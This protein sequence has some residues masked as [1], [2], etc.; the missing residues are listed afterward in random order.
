MT[1]TTETTVKDL[2]DWSWW[3]AALAGNFGPVHDGDLHSG[4][5]R[6]KSKKTGRWIP[7]AIWADDDGEWRGLLGEDIAVDPTD[8]WTWVCRY[9]IA[10]AVYTKARTEGGFIDEPPVIQSPEYLGPHDEI[11]AIRTEL[12]SEIECYA[13]EGHTAPKAGAWAKRISAL[14]TR[15]G[16]A[17]KAEK[18]PFISIGRAIDAKWQPIIASATD[19]LEKL[20][21]EQE[22]A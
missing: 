1:N 4:Y 16:N 20:K 12:Q 3:H 13:K 8:I 11:D 5:Y 6:M 22:A 14:K 19:L 2:N 17:R 21:S 15:A 10:Y 7:A 9:P 18:E